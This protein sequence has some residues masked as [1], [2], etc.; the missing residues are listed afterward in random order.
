MTKVKFSKIVLFCFCCLFSS[1]SNVNEPKN[2]SVIILRSIKQQSLLP[3][4]QFLL[5]V[6]IP[7]RH[8]CSI[9]SV[10]VFSYRPYDRFLQ[11]F[12]LKTNKKHKSSLALML[13]QLRVF[14]AVVFHG[15]ILKNPCKFLPK[16]FVNNA[17]I[18]VYITRQFV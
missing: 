18:Y 10:T 6:K 3:L 7:K 12:G 16:P 13:Q 15:K 5:K 8:V 9:P 1:D 4:E 17:H 14:S 11:K 2:I